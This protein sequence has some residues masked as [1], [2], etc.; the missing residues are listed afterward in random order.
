MWNRQ[1]VE[2]DVWG[3]KRRAS[4]TSVLRFWESL[5]FSMPLAS[6]VP[7][8]ACIL[9]L[10]R[11]EAVVGDRAHKEEILPSSDPS[12][13]HRAWLSLPFKSLSVSVCV[14]LW[15]CALCLCGQV[16]AQSKR[17]HCLMAWKSLGAW[18]LGFQ[19]DQVWANH[20][21]FFSN[22]LLKKQTI[23]ILLPLVL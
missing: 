2:G 6:G 20:L 5:R 10:H 7:P 3:S 19:K 8:E 12:R 23:L 17:G 1:V 13:I 15:V 4:L 22:F 16:L 11:K 21:T 18:Y 14:C 9:I